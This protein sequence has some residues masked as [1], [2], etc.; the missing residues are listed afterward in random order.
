MEVPDEIDR[1]DDR[2]DARDRGRDDDRRDRDD[3]RRDLSRDRDRDDRDR[4]R[5]WAREREER[6]TSVDELR[7]TDQAVAA[8]TAALDLYRADDVAAG[9]AECEARLAR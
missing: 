9:V 1:D 2:R 6:R 4:F 5:D 3:D 7:R 8:W